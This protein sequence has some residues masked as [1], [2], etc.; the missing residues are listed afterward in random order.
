MNDLQGSDQ[1]EQKL[2]SR[3]WFLLPALSILTIIFLFA[4][5]D[6]LSHL[7]FSRF[8]NVHA[9]LIANDPST[10]LRGVPNCT[11][12]DKR[13]EYPFIEYKFNSSG[14][15]SR[16]DFRPKQS[17]TYRIVLVGSSFSFGLGVPNENT[18]GAQ[19]PQ[20]LSTLTGR[21]VELY[22]QAMYLGTPHSTALRFNDAIAANP[23]LI[24]WEVSPWDIEESSSLG[25]IMD[26]THNET[27]EEV[28]W[29]ERSL[30]ERSSTAQ[31]LIT[32][33]KYQFLLVKLRS[34]KLLNITQIRTAF[35]HYLFQSPSIY[36]NNYLKSDDKRAGF[37][38]SEFSPNWQN[39]LHQFEIYASDVSE[40]AKA[41][42]VPLVIVLLP[43]YGQA[44]M[45]SKGE[46]ANGNDPFKL[47]NELRAIIT[48]HG[49][50]SISILQDFRNIPNPA[51][52]FYPVDDHPNVNGNAVI[53]NMLARELTN[54]NIHALNA[55]STQLNAP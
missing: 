5:A 27:D 14:Y 26:K 16:M 28:A 41:A 3:D 35:Q 54:G 45:L 2:P 6:L 33:L 30:E 38:K 24:L 51:E 23:D 34:K 48:R 39:N 53:S 20:K 44:S 8:D 9:C 43:D 29:E 12:M 19:L 37:L 22:N 47:D 46:W 4:F 31:P 21:K 18:F 50:T 17:D 40:R 10:G 55:T 42:G 49:G 13:Y 1:S 11:C 32:R 25:L 15:R 7:M 36:L 52:L